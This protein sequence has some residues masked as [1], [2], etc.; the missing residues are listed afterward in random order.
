[1]AK[2]LFSLECQKCTPNLCG[3][4]HGLTQLKAATVW[5][6]ESTLGSPQRVGVTAC[7]TDEKTEGQVAASLRGTRRGRSRANL[8]S[9]DP[10]YLTVK[11]RLGETFSGWADRANPTEKG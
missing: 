2:A 8:G 11:V 7:L 4:G 1:M 5:R 3:V 6:S 10:I 9:G